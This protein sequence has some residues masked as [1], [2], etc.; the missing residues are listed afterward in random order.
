[1]FQAS[2]MIFKFVGFPNLPNGKQQ[3]KLL[4]VVV[5]AEASLPWSRMAEPLY[6]VHYCRL[7]QVAGHVGRGAKLG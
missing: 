5:V 6:N 4:F 7:S 3:E 2:K 1:M